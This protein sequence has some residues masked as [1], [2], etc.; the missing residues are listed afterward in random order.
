MGMDNY[1]HKFILLDTLFDFFNKIDMIPCNPK[2]ALLLYHRW[3]LSNLSWHLAIADLNETWAIE[4]LD[5]VVTRY[6]RK[7]LNY[8]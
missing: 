7:C 3:V 8:P 5:S 2:N 4:N 6:I 1:K